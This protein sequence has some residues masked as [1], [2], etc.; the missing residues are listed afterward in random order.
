MLI[1]E[2]QLQI[3]FPSAGN[4]SPTPSAS[5]LTLHCF[6]HSPSPGE[7]ED[8]HGRGC[9]LSVRISTELHPIPRTASVLT[10]GQVA[11][12]PASP[13]VSICFI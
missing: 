9:R 2:S 10:I 12:M 3:A 13:E 4:L 5:Y 1:Q 11:K 7:A 6:Q 8:C